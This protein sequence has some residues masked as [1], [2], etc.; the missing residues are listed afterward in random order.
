MSKQV[1]LSEAAQTIENGD[2]LAL[3]G[4]AL[5]R[6]PNAFVLELV[7]QEKQGLSVIKTAGA[8]DVDLLAAAGALASVHGG[9]IGFEMFGLAPAYRKGV[10]NGDIIA[11]EHAC[12]SVIAALKASIYSVPFQPI[13]GFHG[14]DLPHL[15][16]LIKQVI[17]PFTNQKTPVVEALKPDV[18]IIHAHVADEAGNAYIE[19][20]LYEDEI[21]AKAAKRV[22]VT[23][24][25]VIAST[26]WTVQPNIPGFLVEHV[27]H[28]PQGA[29][30]GSCA[31]LYDIDSTEVTRYLKS[32]IDYVNGQEAH[33]HG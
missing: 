29:A 8:L 7:Q 20:P 4:N 12:A 11:H 16:G 18:T 23:A 14:S 17:C 22:I 31:P 28:T 2:L 27:V 6:S 33:I 10:Q 15:T 21:M 30:P 32:P 9:Y 3:G 5:H 25:K 26:D 19:G 24:E 1:K 13:N